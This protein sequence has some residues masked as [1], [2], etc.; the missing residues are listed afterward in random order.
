MSSSTKT[1]LSLPRLQGTGNYPIWKV[2]VSA[3][4]IKKGFLDAI[5]QEPSNAAET[6]R[7]KRALAKIQLLYDDGPLIQI[8]NAETAYQA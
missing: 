5:S 1:I 4:L 2:R 8:K 3:Y 7:S 6:G